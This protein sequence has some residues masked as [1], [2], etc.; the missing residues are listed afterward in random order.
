MKR[1]SY[2]RSINI[3]VQYVIINTLGPNQFKVHMRYL[4]KCLEI[5]S[6]KKDIFQWKQISVRKILLIGFII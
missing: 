3:D 4:V 6:F 1:Y 2:N 5:K